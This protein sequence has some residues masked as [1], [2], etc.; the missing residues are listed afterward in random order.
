MKQVSARVRKFQEFV[1][2][3]IVYG[4]LDTDDLQSLT[5][6]ILHVDPTDT[7]LIN[8]EIETYFK[9]N[10]EKYGLLFDEQSV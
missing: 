2:V 6:F 7:N 4:I 9:E 1:L 10:A 5:S 3:T 8:D